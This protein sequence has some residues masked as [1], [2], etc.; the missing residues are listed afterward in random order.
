MHIQILSWWHMTRICFLTVFQQ[1]KW[2][3]KE[4][5]EWDK[6]R[7]DLCWW[8]LGLEDWSMEALLFCSS[9]PCFLFLLGLWTPRAPLSLHFLLHLDIVQLANCEVKLLRGWRELLSVG[10]PVALMSWGAWGWARFVIPPS[11]KEPHRA[12]WPLSRWRAWLEDK[13]ACLV[14]EHGETC[15]HSTTRFSSR[16]FRATS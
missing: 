10:W 13:T 6:L 2:I 8:L 1:D 7:L 14:K 15:W 5:C 12:A 16:L 9:V 4:Q 11:S 3:G